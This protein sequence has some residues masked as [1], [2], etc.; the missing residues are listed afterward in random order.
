[1]EYQKAKLKTWE[2]FSEIAL[3]LDDAVSSLQEIEVLLMASDF[4]KCFEQIADLQQL[5]GRLASVNIKKLKQEMKRCQDVR[6]KIIER[7]LRG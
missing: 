1:M 5:V 2:A 3:K 4:Q 7:G 6:Q